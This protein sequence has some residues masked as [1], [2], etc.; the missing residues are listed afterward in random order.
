MLR[1]ELK[2]GESVRIGDDILV[3]LEEKSGQRARVAFSADR[4]IPI[5][6]VKGGKGGSRLAATLGIT[7]DPVPA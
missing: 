7:G 5:R 1:I 6:K 2:P 3:T 4:S